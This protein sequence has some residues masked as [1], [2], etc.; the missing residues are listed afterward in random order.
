MGVKNLLQNLF[1]RKQDLNVLL[2]YLIPQQITSPY[3]HLSIF[4]SIDFLFMCV[5]PT[6]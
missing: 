3:T 2:Y 5:S 4:T 6:K 1:Y